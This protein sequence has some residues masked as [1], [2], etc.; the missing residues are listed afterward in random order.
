MMGT[1]SENLQTNYHPV[2][3]P[4]VFL[5]LLLQGADQ[6]MQTEMC[7]GAGLADTV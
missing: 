1:T 6:E 7:T 3:E 4:E 2:V 5:C